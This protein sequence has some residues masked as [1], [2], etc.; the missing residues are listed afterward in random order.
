MSP[1]HPSVD[2]Y[3]G[4][5]RVELVVPPCTPS[6]PLPNSLFTSFPAPEGDI[7]DPDVGEGVRRL[8]VFELHQMLFPPTAMDDTSQ[9]AEEHYAEKLANEEGLELLQ[10]N[11]ELLLALL[12]PCLLEGDPVPAP[13]R[14]TSETFQAGEIGSNKSEDF[15][16]DPETSPVPALHVSTNPSPPLLRSADVCTA[17]HITDVDLAH[18]REPGMID[19]IYYSYIVFL[20]FL[21]WKVHDEKRGMLDR[22]RS[23]RRRYELLA[24]LALSSKPEDDLTDAFCS[25]DDRSSRK[26]AEALSTS[27]GDGGCITP[28][29]IGHAHSNGVSGRVSRASKSPL[30]RFK[31]GH[32]DFY[33]DAIPR[34]LR[35]FLSIGFLTISVRLVEFIIEEMAAGRIEFLYDLVEKQALPALNSCTAIDASHIRRLTKMFHSLTQS[36]SD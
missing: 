36:D 30:R 18:L 1:S 9:L 17:A 12:F 13:S 20:R 27:S 34:M 26:P 2:F 29:G 3:R 15:E 23:W 4:R 21:G 14:P 19:R 8:G 28:S 16:K 22:H 10:W 7:E 5:T 31:Y 11:W 24:P 33:C 32:F 35:C 6:A 25:G